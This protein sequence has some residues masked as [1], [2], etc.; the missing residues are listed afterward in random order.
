M[1]ENAVDGG[2]DDGVLL[3]ERM[4]VCKKVEKMCGLR[5]LKTS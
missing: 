2:D 4:C 1:C 3:F 5:D